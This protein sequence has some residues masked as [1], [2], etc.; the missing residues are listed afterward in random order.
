MNNFEGIRERGG[1]EVNYKKFNMK[2]KME[3]EDWKQM[4]GWTKWN[5]R[6][7][8]DIKDERSN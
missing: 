2:I 1:N 7:Q 5:G 3:E 8:E 4:K 6:I